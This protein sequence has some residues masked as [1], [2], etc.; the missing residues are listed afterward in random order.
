MVAAPAP[1]TVRRALAS[2]HV[3][4]PPLVPTRWPLPL[5]AAGAA[6]LLAPAALAA[7][8][9]TGVLRG[10]VTSAE[11]APLRNVRVAVSPAAGGPALAATTDAGGRFQV[12]V[13]AGGYELALRAVGFRPAARGRLAVARGDTTDVALTLDRLVSELSTVVTTATRTAATVGAVPG[14]V[15][16]VERE[17]IAA[18]TRLT[19][20]LGAALAQLV[21]GLAAGTETVSN[22]GQNLRGRTVL[23]LIDG[24]PQ[25]TNRNV[26]RDFV[27]IDPAM[28][29][30]VEVLR[31]ASAVYG[32]GATG[33]VINIVTRRG[34]ADR[35][36][37]T[38]ELQ[39]EGAPA[40]LGASVGPRLSQTVS[41]TRGA[42]DFLAGGVLTRT[43]ATFDGAGDRIPGDP[44]G[45]GGVAE[46]NGWDVLGK[47]GWTR[48]A[49]L[50]R[51]SANR[52][53]SRQ[54]TDYATD[55]A[56]AQAPAGTKSRVREGLDL[57]R[58]Q[59]TD[60]TVL[61]LTYAHTAV[62]GSQVRAQAYWRDYAT[63][64]GP[65][66]NRAVASLG[67]LIFQSYVDSRRA[68]GRLEVETPVARRLGASLLWGADYSDETT[69]QPV[70]VFDPAAFD[71]SGGLAFRRTG[72]RL[73]VPPIDARNLGL[74]AQLT[75]RPAAR[76]VLHGGARHE[77]AAFG[78]GDFT[79]LNGVAF[80]G[81]TLRFAP[82]LAN[83]GAVLTLS[84]PL[85]VY[86]N[87]A[88]GFSLADLGRTVRQPPAGFTLRARDAEAQR[89]DQ[90][91][92]G[93][94]GGWARVQASAAGFRNTSRLGTA[95]GPTLEVVRA[96][97]RVYGV[98]GTL[99][100][101]PAAR[102]ALG[103]T[104]TWTEGDFRTARPGG[105]AGDSVW[106]PLN[107]FRIQP[108]KLTAY[109][110]HRTTAR[111]QTRLQLLHSGA[112]DRAHDA[113]LARPGANPAAPGFGERRVTAYTTVDLLSRLTLARPGRDRGTLS[114][115]VRNLFDAQYFPVVSQLQPIG[116]VSFS[117]A[118]GRV[119][120]LG[121]AVTY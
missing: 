47:V 94:R 38:T 17:Q 89:V 74:F 26:T 79:A 32:E 43:G 57:A 54:A 73:F 76:L 49:Q 2:P 91:E 83:A 19:P 119:L 11:G 88:Q 101:Q 62:L 45:Q 21:P 16:V 84:R 14:A 120:T 51:L 42:W 44:T 56:V 80:A 9:D 22:F 121:Y 70:D 25:S 109:A 15:T 27:N 34:S 82:T 13:P 116:P 69:S 35:L 106:R 55:P 1:G 59:G 36:E 102:L 7:Q 96:P 99:D 52:V 118:P 33:G 6:V 113:F 107:S 65:G 37:R 85:S 53:R 5:R 108:L 29:E 97:E 103:G 100:V 66:D 72:T 104:A 63:R 60:N 23:V 30:R 105:A 81:G 3:M 111:W 75:A 41:G 61:N 86:A 64:F 78:V 40:A 95:F 48:G 18:Q 46:T 71:A 114:V 68:G 77:R 67:R 39:L 98:E 92:A 8:T 93:V 87:Y 115:G 117:A 112:R 31:G 4:L 12:R 20:R 28:V 24:V 110:E 10:R 58:G 50:V 90:A